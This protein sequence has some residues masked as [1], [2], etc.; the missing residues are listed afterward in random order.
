MH[1]IIGES[2]NVMLATHS[3]EKLAKAQVG[4]GVTVRKYRGEGGGGSR[5]NAY[6]PASGGRVPD[7]GSSCLGSTDMKERS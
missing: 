2:L 4:N 6:G 1:L 3:S 7:S 5:L